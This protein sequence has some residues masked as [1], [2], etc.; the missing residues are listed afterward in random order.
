MEPMREETAKVTVFVGGRV[1]DVA[2]CS[3]EDANRVA[4]EI[5]SR[6]GKEAQGSVMVKDKKG[7]ITS[8]WIVT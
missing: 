6:Y 2:L 4:R 5:M 1:A 8:T 3:P 7:G